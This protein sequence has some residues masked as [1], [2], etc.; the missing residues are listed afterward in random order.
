MG[1]R[2]PRSSSLTCPRASGAQSENK[3]LQQRRNRRRKVGEPTPKARRTMKLQLFSGTSFCKPMPSQ[4]KS[5]PNQKTNR[6]THHIRHWADIH[7]TNK[8]LHTRRPRIC[9]PGCCST[10]CP[11]QRAKDPRKPTCQKQHRGLCM[12]VLPLRT[13]N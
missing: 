9:T 4:T 8:I 1:F 2:G 10:A 12:N 11:I 5:A 3:E 7:E 6:R 13:D